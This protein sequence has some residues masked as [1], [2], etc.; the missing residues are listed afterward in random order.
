MIVVVLKLL[1][2]FFG[3]TALYKRKYSNVK[4]KIYGI[5]LNCTK[6]YRLKRSYPEN[7]HECR[8]H[9]VFYFPQILFNQVRLLQT[10]CKQFMFKMY[11]NKLAGYCWSLFNFSL[12][13]Q[14]KMHPK[15]FW[16]AWLRLVR[17]DILCSFFI[18]F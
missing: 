11:F 9:M 14:W 10:L 4:A 12:R 3:K 13:S 2:I 7:V 5:F 18:F 15:A 8:Y 17:S 16:R 6:V 1:L